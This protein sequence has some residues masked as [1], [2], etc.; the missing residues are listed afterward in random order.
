M[1]AGPFRFKI[2]SLFPVVIAAVFVTLSGV[3]AQY[4]GRNKV[5]Y[6]KFDFKVL[7]TPHFKIF[8]Y[9]QERRAAEDA[10]RMAERWYVRLSNV[11]QHK[12]LVKKPIVFYADHPDFQQTNIIGGFIGEGTGGVTEGLKNRVVLPFTGIYRENDHV[13][14]HELVHAFQYDFAERRGRRGLVAMSRLPLWVVE[15][16]AEYFSLGNHDTNTAMWL[17]D[18]ALQKNL[19]TIKQLTRDPRFFPYRYGQALWAYIGGRWGDTM[20]TQLYKQSNIFGFGGAIDSALGMSPDSLSKVW[21]QDIKKAYLPI[22]KGRT[23]PKDVGKK[24]LAKDIDAG[25]MN[26]APVI[27]P[28]GKYVAFMSERDLFSIDLFMADSHT[29]KVVKK[30]A[31]ANRDSH[32]DALS[33][34][35]SSG[36]W[37]PDASKFAMVVIGGGDD[38]IG[39]VDIKAGKIKKRLHFKNIPGISNTAWSPDGRYLA[40][41]GSHGGIS[42]LYLYD[43]QT[44]KIQQLTDDRYADLQPTWSP[45]GKKIAFVSDRGAGTDFNHLA[46]HD[47]GIAVLDV[48]TKK[49]DVLDLFPRGKHINPQYSPDGTSL[50][51]ISDQD[52]FP[53]IYRVN[54]AANQIYRVTKVA[55]GV[56]GITSLS[57]A[58]TIS[59]ITGRMLFSVFEHSHYTV[60]GRDAEETLG[61]PIERGTAITPA[62]AGML[63]PLVSNSDNVVEKYLADSRTGLPRSP[64]YVTTKYHSRFQLDYI[65]QSTIGVSADRF[66]TALG[67]GASAFFSDMLGDKVIG[68][69]VLANG[70]VK[71]I[72]GQFFY[73]DRGGQTN[74]GAAVAHIPFLTLRT[75]IRPVVVDIGG[76]KFNGLETQQILD[77]VFLDRAVGLVEFPLSTT[78]RFE[79]NGGFTHIGYNREIETFTTIG[80]QVVAHDKSS[81]PAP[82]GL[83]LVQASGAFVSDNSIF[84]FTSPIAGTRYRLEIEPTFGSLQ[85]FSALIDFRKYIKVN[86]FTFAFRALHYGRYGKDSDSNRLNPLFIGYE[87]FVRGYDINS[88]TG[89][90]CT[91]SSP[92]ALDCPE[93]DRLIGSR[94]GVMNLEFRIPVLG[95]ERF[96]L[97]DFPYLPTE[98]V[99]FVDGGI[100]WDR[101]H[102]PKIKFARRSTERIPV[103]STGISLRVNL[104]GIFIMESYLAYPFQRPGRGA[105]LGFQIAPG[106]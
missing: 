60:F 19:P 15:G 44:G 83:S 37:S 2:T 30:L 16:L 93:F 3:Q 38:Q 78:Q 50:Y 24:I 27:S 12:F 35:N 63:P 23:N 53:D 58:M 68:A 62:I 77:R 64:Q 82:P 45:D 89:E 18:A 29:G 14:G 84:G 34:I 47:L 70:G 104:L 88:F 98:F 97:L 99:A 51:F 106:W 92:G 6:Q 76:Q 103:F 32:L 57:P 17:R 21:I 52:G 4:F 7:Q 90:E 42:D 61:I 96:G 56:S 87:T 33:F 36:S 1:S 26:V 10:A 66:G 101:N 22:M 81:A 71:D 54:L 102:T 73:Q 43:F 80:G 100:A 86:Q 46:Y 8:Y 9:P 13:L 5:N 94:I 20:V 95:N 31:D 11:F 41:A 49:I 25:D 55:T 91:P 40:I 59:P 74:L 48:E 85:Y 79:L 67:G 75:G 28:D 69:S 72:G 105:I 39:I 65:G